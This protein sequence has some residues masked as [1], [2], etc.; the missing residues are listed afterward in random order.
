[1]SNA[2]TIAPGFSAGALSIEND[3]T[4]ASMSVLS[5]EVGGL[6]QGTQYDLLTEG[7]SVA[8]NL[9]GSLSVSLIN[10]FVPDSAALFTVVSS[11]QNLNGTFLNIANGARL[12]SNGG[13][14]F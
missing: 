7:G 11:N 6:A 10:G 3:L 1:M 5:I 4:L 2:G 12:F 14:S 8:L 13:G 9:N